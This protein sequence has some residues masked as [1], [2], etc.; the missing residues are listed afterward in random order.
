MKFIKISISAIYIGLFH[1]MALCSC[2]WIQRRLTDRAAFWNGTD[3]KY[4][5]DGN[6]YDNGCSCASAQKANILTIENGS[7]VKCKGGPEIEK[8]T[9]DGKNTYLFYHSTQYLIFRQKLQPYF[10]YCSNYLGLVLRYEVEKCILGKKNPCMAVIWFYFSQLILPE[11]KSF[12]KYYSLY[13]LDTW[14]KTLLQKSFLIDWII[15]FKF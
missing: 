10:H 1:C 6:I 2:F 7:H 3:C 14:V 12:T 9:R 8:L 13:S 5:G 11:I 4:L 15:S